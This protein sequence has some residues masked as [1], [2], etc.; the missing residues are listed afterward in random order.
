MGR[1]SQEEIGAEK[2]LS[3]GVMFAEE[4]LNV[5]AFSSFSTRRRV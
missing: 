4:A 2:S 1:S 3:S 5:A